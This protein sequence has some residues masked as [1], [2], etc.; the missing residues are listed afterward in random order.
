MFT[1]DTIFLALSGICKSTR[2]T[3]VNTVAPSA[4]KLVYKVYVRALTVWTVVFSR[5]LIFLLYQD[6]LLPNIRGGPGHWCL[7]QEVGHHLEG[8][9]DGDAILR[10]EISSVWPCY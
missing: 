7:P 2:N 10:L 5:L 8:H 4:L 9:L 1:S 6:W 3:P